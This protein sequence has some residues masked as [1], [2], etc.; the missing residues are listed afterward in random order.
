[1]T[2]KTSQFHTGL[3]TRRSVL[4]KSAG[5]AAVGAIG[6]NA[7]RAKAPSTNKVIVYKTPTCGCCTAWVEHIEAAG[8]EPRIVEMADLSPVRKKYG[9]PIEL[10]SCHIAVA[11]GYVVEGHVPAEAIKK[12]LAERP[13][14]VGIFAPG[15][16][17]GSPGMESPYGAQPY[18]VILLRNDGVQEKFARYNA[19]REH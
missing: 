7:A 1:M 19:D 6:I 15:M 10:V 12:L 14:A 2:C 18:D 5:L 13:D 8:F 3:H 9:A 17:L 11:D 4:L 16:P